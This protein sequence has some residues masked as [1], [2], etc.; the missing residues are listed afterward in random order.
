MSLKSIQAFTLVEIVITVGIVTILS[1]IAI[2]NY[3]EFNDRLTISSAGQ[4]MAVNI[5]QSQS[6][7]LNVKEVAPSGGNFSAAY[8]VHLSKNSSDNTSYI[9]FSD[10]NGNKKYDPA[11]GCGSPGSECVEK[12]S[13][14]NGVTVSDVNATGSCPSTNLAQSMTITFLRPNPDADINF[15]NSSG[16]GV[17]LS[18][19]NALITVL[20]K[21]GRTI[22]LSV[23]STG[24]IS[25]Q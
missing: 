8:G 20:S 6:Y 7:G 15:F 4:E 17:C 9:I 18:S 5:R 12:V 24:Q 25:V 2:T 13:L 10:I 3:Y 11:G 21:G 16:I 23:E 22:I 1:S 19:P 14:R